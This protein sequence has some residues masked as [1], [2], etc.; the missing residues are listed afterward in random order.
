MIAADA[1]PFDGR[2]TVVSVRNGG[3]GSLYHWN[4]GL[5]LKK[6]SLYYI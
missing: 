4:V 3:A 6:A 1:E 5:A 2:V